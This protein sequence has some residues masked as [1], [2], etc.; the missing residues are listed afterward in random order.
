MSSPPDSETDTPEADLPTI[1]QLLDEAAVECAEKKDYLSFSTIVDVYTSDLSKL[2]DE[3]KIKM[4]DKLYEVLEANPQLTYNISWDLPPIFIRFLDSSWTPRAGG[5]RSLP[6]SKVLKLFE[7]LC[8]HGASKEL[9]VTCCDLIA[10]LRP[11]P[12]IQDRKRAE[13]V[14]PDTV[15]RF[16]QINPR[17]MFSIKFHSLMETIMSCIR[18]N[19]TLHPSK[20][21]TAVIGSLINFMQCTRSAA[22]LPEVRRIYRFIR[23]YIPPD[24]PESVEP[25]PEIASVVADENYLQRKQLIMLMGNAV[26]CTSKPA[27]SALV[28][29][30]VPSIKYESL[31]PQEDS[32]RLDLLGR[33]VALGLSMDLD[34]TELMSHELAI[35]ERMFSG[36]DL[37]A[38]DDI[39]RN[40]IDGY[41]KDLLKSQEQLTFSP[42]ATTIL[43]TYGAL[44]TNE[45]ID[46]DILDLV[47]LIKLQLRLFVP[48]T[49][50]PSLVLHS[51]VACLM[52]LTLLV[53]DKDPA[54][55]LKEL[56]KPSHVLLVMT[57]LQNLSSLCMNSQTPVLIQ[58]FFDFLVKFLLQMPEETTYNFLV[59][60]IANCPFEGLQTH[61]AIVLKQMMEQERVAEHDSQL[62]GPKIPARRYIQN[63][64]DRSNEVLALLDD[65]IKDTTVD[66]STDRCARLLA[67]SGLCSEEF[68]NEYSSRVD[69]VKALGEQLSQ[70]TDSSKRTI[71]DRLR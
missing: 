2:S 42:L 68:A 69:S 44:A 26:E 19:P 43:Y 1:L 41:N 53:L 47:Q 54:K 37:K 28:S 5:L 30:L 67:L 45:T 3:E 8:L 11:I 36:P 49:L 7:L 62:D 56:N 23:D 50:N 27:T 52:I 66:A 39:F 60:T 40:V 10:Q 55:S 58:F 9:L 51:A 34:F 59:D 63:T 22:Q 57:Y 61:A 35:S 14:D 16:Y 4:M 46:T 13:G 38:S 32:G 31:V 64:P 25:N 6:T 29:Y 24:L 65:A 48:F 15:R 12:A 20:Y 33:F 71:G 70:Q 18:S 17:R 21:L